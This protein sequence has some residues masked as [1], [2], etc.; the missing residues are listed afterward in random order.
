M[1][2]QPLITH[3]A[4]SCVMCKGGLLIG[5]NYSS[6]LIPKEI[7]AAKDDDPYT[8]KTYLVWGV[9]GAI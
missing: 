2:L 5:F 4:K 9:T 3:D 1:Y 6:A 7:K 8:V